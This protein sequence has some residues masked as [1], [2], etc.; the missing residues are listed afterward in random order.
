MVEVSCCEIESVLFFR[1]C[2]QPL[3]LVSWTIQNLVLYDVV[4]LEIPYGVVREAVAWS[5]VEGSDCW[6][7]KS[8]RDEWWMT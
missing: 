8:S 3:D 5:L 6:V 1:V 7:Q 4:R 2:V